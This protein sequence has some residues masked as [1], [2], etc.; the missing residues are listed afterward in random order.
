MGRQKGRRQVVIYLPPE[1]HDRLKIEAAKTRTTMSELVESALSR[2]RR[3]LLV[4]SK[5]KR[6]ADP[7]GAEGR[8]RAGEAQGSAVVNAAYLSR[9]RRGAPRG[10]GKDGR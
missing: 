9:R 6:A 5:D 2:W 8:A 3:I 7:T 1:V 4:P 10:R